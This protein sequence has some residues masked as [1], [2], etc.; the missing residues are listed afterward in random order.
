MIR[1]LFV[2]LLGAGAVWAQ[3]APETAEKPPTGTLSGRVEIELRSDAKQALPNLAMALCPE[4][5][6]P[7][8]KHLRE[9]RWR[10]TARLY[11]F[12][13]GYNNLDLKALGQKAVSAAVAEFKSDDK[14]K[15]RREGIPPGKYVI[16]AQY[17]SKYAAAYW[18]VPVEVKGGEVSEVVLTNANMKEIYNRF[19]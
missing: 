11:A 14:G 5:I 17:K 1:W 16:Y 6:A 2:L 4:S 13:D 9:E 3:P 7:E 10:E 18:L 8:M 12:N 19:N 15:F